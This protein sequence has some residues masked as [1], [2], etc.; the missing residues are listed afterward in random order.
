[1]AK[2]IQRSREQIEDE[3]LAFEL[4]ERRC[5]LGLTVVLY[6]L[7]VVFATLGEHWP[8]PSVPGVL[9]TASAYTAHRRT[10]V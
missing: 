8:V 3:L 9:G 7:A 5:F 6:A 10:R 2:E 1:M 4:T